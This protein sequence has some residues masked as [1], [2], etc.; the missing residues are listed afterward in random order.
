MALGAC[1]HASVRTLTDWLAYFS[2]TSVSYF[3][4]SPCSHIFQP[5]GR[6]VQVG[7]MFLLSRQVWRQTGSL[8]AARCLFQVMRYTTAFAVALPCHSG[9]VSPEAGHPRG[10]E[11]PFSSILVHCC[12]QPWHVWFVS[13]TWDWER[14]DIASY[15]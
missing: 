15:G 10:K 13:T 4:N 14:K 3:R 5:S 9:T 8:A 6:Q 11:L 1:T 2:F 12:L 7:I